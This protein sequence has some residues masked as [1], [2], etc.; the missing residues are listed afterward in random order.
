VSWQQVPHRLS[1]AGHPLTG[2]VTELH[3]AI[4]ALDAD[5]VPESYHQR[6]LACRQGAPSPIG[7]LSGSLGIR[8]NNVHRPGDARP[9]VLVR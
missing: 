4:D 9:A 7:Q 2:T 5:T 3:A 6:V 1:Y 8:P